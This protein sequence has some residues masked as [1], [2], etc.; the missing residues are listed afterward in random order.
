MLVKSVVTLTLFTTS[1]FAQSLLEAI[2]GYPGLTNFVTLLQN[3]PNLANA[4]LSN[5]NRSSLSLSEPTTVLIPSNEAFRKESTLFG[6]PYQNLTVEQLQPYLQ[7]HLLV[8]S[9]TSTNLTNST[10][11][12]PSFLSAEQYNNRS[13]GAALGADTSG[14]HNGQV[15]IL[16]PIRTSSNKFLIRQLGG[17]SAQGGFIDKVVRIFLN[18]SQMPI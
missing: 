15:V 10:L 2:A 8:G 16:S 18:T 11:T 12:V 7:Y 4:L 3:N 9:V 13:A 6:L 5:A 1:T 14:S 17:I